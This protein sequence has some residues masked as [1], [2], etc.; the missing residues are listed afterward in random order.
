M[1]LNCFSQLGLVL[2]IIG[3]LL[4]F[5]YGLPSKYVE[6]PGSR[7]I[8]TETNTDLLKADEKK[9]SAIMLW[10]RVGLALIILGFA[11]QLI[12]SFA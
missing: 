9:N 12:G 11:G 8:I 3:A 6:A 10:S 1:D 4:L 7:R 5:R 2:D